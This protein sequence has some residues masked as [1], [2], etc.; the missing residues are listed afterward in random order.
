M[1][2][3]K[4]FSSTARKKPPPGAAESQKITEGQK[5]DYANRWK[6][7]ETDRQ[8]DKKIDAQIYCLTE[9]QMQMDIQPERKT[10]KP[11]KYASTL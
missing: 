5:D 4:C 7:R 9:R 11:D 3:M 2:I 6:E 10:H 8:S 1:E